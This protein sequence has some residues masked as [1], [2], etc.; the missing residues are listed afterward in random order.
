MASTYRV[1]IKVLP[2]TGG[3]ASATVTEFMG[4]DGNSS[5]FQDS[6]EFSKLNRFVFTATPNKGWKFLYWKYVRNGEFI[7]Y[8][9]TNPAN[10]T[11]GPSMEAEINEYVITAYFVEYSLELAGYVGINDK[12][13]K[14][15]QGYVGIDGKSRKL[16]K[17]Y[18]GVENKARLIWNV[19][20]GEMPK[21]ELEI[22]DLVWHTTPLPSNGSWH[23]IAFG[24]NRF[25]AITANRD[26][27]FS[28]GK[29]AYSLDGVGWISS[30]MPSGAFSTGTWSRIAFGK[31][32]FVVTSSGG[33]KVA[34]TEDGV[35]WKTSQMPYTGNWNQLAFGNDRFVAIDTS[36]ERGA[37]SNDGVTW[38]PTTVPTSAMGRGLTFG[39]GMFITVRYG[40]G[41]GAY[42]F[43]GLDWYSFSLPEVAYWNDVGYV[44][45]T[46]IAVSSVMSTKAAKS[47]N[48][49]T[50]EKSTL[51]KAAD[52]NRIAS[53]DKSLIAIAP[54]ITGE[55]E[56]GGLCACTVNGNDWKLTNI[57]SRGTWGPAAY[58]LGK[59]VVLGDRTNDIGVAAY[60][61]A[62]GG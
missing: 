9:S 55:S 23:G 30:S 8:W 54:P 59:F 25:V 22:P 58:G 61:D 53:G 12:S 60:A 48:G 2:V 5:Q 47:T 42:S 29:A 1:T 44:N 62:R 41:I 51:P 10:T 57:L 13:K 19:K 50:W 36:N 45:D 39:N 17:G 32:K 7:E 18:V 38:Y 24:N 21:P 56:N 35:N 26:P 14:L 46:F 16:V 28:E 43:N 15:T 49:R 6:A 52:W 34:Y 20:V 4:E 37:Y 11:F 3:S 27:Y 40:Y 33:I 31:D